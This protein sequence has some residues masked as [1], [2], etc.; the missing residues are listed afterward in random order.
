MVMAEEHG[1]AK[2]LLKMLDD[3]HVVHAV[4]ARRVENHAV[5]EIQRAN[6]ADADAGHLLLVADGLF[7]G[8]NGRAHQRFLVE[9][10]QLHAHFSNGVHLKIAQHRRDVFDLKQHAG[11]LRRVGRQRKRLRHIARRALGAGL[12]LHIALI[13]ELRDDVGQSHLGQAAPAGELRARGL[14]VGDNLLKNQTAVKLL[15]MQVIDPLFHKYHPPNQIQCIK[16][17]T[18]FQAPAAG[19]V[20]IHFTPSI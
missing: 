9:L 19:F 3:G 6:G 15:L 12:F 18:F 8:A 13:D 7:H 10:R 4:K 20:K 1:Q 11:D 5:L 17:R 2:M 16:F 14:L